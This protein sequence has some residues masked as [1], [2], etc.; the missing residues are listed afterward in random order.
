M[1]TKK[2]VVGAIAASM[3]SLS[4]CSLAPAV[5]AAGETVQISASEESAKAGE[6][7]TVNVSIGDIPS[8]GI[9]I[10]DFAIKYDS[11]L[12]TIDSV[13]AGAI[14]ETGADS[15]DSSASSQP[16]F[17]SVKGEGSINLL[18]TTM[19]ED[20]KYWITKD[21]VFCTLSGTVNSSAKDGAVAKIELVPTVRDTYSGSGVKNDKISC[22]YLKNNEQIEYEVKAVNGSVTVGTPVPTEATTEATTS[23]ATTTSANENTTGA[24]GSTGGNATLRGDANCDEQVNLADAVLI[25]Q[26][27][28]NPDK[29]GLGKADGITKQGEINGDVVGNNDGLTNKDALQIQK[30]KLGLVTTL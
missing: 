29:Y 20:S 24:Q 10:V 21:G 12:I 26:S 4:V 25:M 2:I 22:G 7:F 1:K 13:K 9:S 5:F 23:A 27:V 28:S 16:L 15:A 14:T 3:L 6:K 30:Y 17:D 8:A 11:S 18:W 19:L